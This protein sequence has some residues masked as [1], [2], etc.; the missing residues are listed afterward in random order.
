M[1]PEPDKIELAIILSNG[2]TDIVGRFTPEDAERY[3]KE[4]ADQQFAWR[5]VCEECEME[6]ENA[7]KHTHG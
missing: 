4:N 2:Y 1:E 3:L 5:W 7:N 6:L